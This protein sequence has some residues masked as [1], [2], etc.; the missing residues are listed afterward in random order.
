[1]PGGAGLVRLTRD[2]DALNRSV[3]GNWFV[4]SA[5]NLSPGYEHAFH[6][7]LQR[8]V[9]SGANAWLLEANYTGNLG[10]TLPYYL[11]ARRAHS[12]R[13]LQQ[14]RPPR[15]ASEQSS[16]QSLRWLRS[17]IYRYGLGDDSLRPPLP[18]QSALD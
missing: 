3:M 9:G 12:A 10:R 11:G 1:M 16:R 18:A 4:S 13:C 5:T 8:E 15:P 2:I 17:A 7:G 6:F 14:D